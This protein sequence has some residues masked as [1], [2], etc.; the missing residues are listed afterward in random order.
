MQNCVSS[1]RFSVDLPPFSNDSLTLAGL[2]LD[3]IR[4][5]VKNNLGECK[6]NMRLVCFYNIHLFKN[7]NV[8]II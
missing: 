7:D 1:K 8:F 4:L 2:P 3:L 6:N 5:I